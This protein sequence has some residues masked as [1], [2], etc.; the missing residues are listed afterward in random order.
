LAGQ[1]APTARVH[2]GQPD[3][4]RINDHALAGGDC[5]DARQWLA[6]QVDPSFCGL[7][8]H[9]EPISVHCRDGVHPQGGDQRVVVHLV[10]SHAL[11]SWR[12][13][14]VT[15]ET[16]VHVRGRAIHQVQHPFSGQGPM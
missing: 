5:N 4:D 10:H 16:S 15:T 13:L 6:D 8:A 11:R 7:V 1:A 3:I 9:R 2:E 12:F 14:P